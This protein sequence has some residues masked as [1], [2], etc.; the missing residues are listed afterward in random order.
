MAHPLRTKEKIES[1]ANATE[2]LESFQNRFSPVDLEELL[3]ELTHA[4]LM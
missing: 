2:P 4:R 3:K 1:M